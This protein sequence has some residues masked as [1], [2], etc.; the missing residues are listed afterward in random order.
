VNHFKLPLP[1]ALS[2]VKMSGVLTS[3]TRQP[4]ERDMQLSN[5][6]PSTKNLAADCGKTLA[7]I[8]VATEST[9]WAMAHKGSVDAAT[10]APMI[11][12]FL[13]ATVP[14]DASG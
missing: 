8:R 9:V 10:T 7:S 2:N 3:S 5:G 6:R 12:S 14:K 11:L 13:I 4:E 1:E